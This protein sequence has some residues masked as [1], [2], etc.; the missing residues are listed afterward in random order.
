MV[1][2]I[3]SES[4]HLPTAM[5]LRV[6]PFHFDLLCPSARICLI[7]LFALLIVAVSPGSSFGSLG[8]FDMLKLFLPNLCRFALRQS[9]FR[10]PIDFNRL[11]VDIDTN[12]DCEELGSCSHTWR[13]WRH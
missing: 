7:Y 9:I 10:K 1:K 8:S 2:R 11:E 5:H 12:F 13:R 4:L 3:L 6:C